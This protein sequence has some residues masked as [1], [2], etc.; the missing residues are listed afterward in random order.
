VIVQA[1]QCRRASSKRLANI[2]RST[3]SNGGLKEWTPHKRPGRAGC[4]EFRRLQHFRAEERA[5]DM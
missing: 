4:D 5:C 2:R 1:R 3:E